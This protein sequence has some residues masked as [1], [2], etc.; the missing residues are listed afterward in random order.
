[1]PK[2]P[3]IRRSATWTGDGSFTYT[4]NAGATGT[5]SFTYRASDGY[6]TS[7]VATVVL[8]IGADPTPPTSTSTTSVPAVVTTTRPTAAV[9][10]TDTTVG[11]LPR[12]GT[13]SRSQVLYGLALVV[14]GG[15]ALVARRRLRSA[16]TST[17]R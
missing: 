14:I 15:S 4:P 6:A 2:Q 16:S 17:S 10:P 5:D 3:T 11:P 9:A 8:T 12:T 1:M 13:D 7:A